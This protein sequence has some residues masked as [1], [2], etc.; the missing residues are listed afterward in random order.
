M[1]L[2]ETY[3]A[4]VAALLSADAAIARCQF[5]IQVTW[6]EWQSPQ[7]CTYTE[8]ARA[9]YRRYPRITRYRLAETL[10]GFTGSIF[11]MDGSYGVVWQ[12]PGT[13]CH[14]GMRTLRTAETRFMAGLDRADI[15]RCIVAR[16]PVY[17]RN[18]EQ[19]QRVARD[20]KQLD[21]D[22][23]RKLNAVL[24]GVKL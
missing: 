15:R 9:M 16:M 18:V 19:I 7:D 12:Q 10:A 21:A 20:F 17:A 3:R 22:T 6:T 2:E 23:Q 4:A 1:S 14:W 8:W 13:P 24:R 5:D 11:C